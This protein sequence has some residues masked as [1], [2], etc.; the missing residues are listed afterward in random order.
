M[1][2]SQAPHVPPRG[3]VCS[4]NRSLCRRP[5]FDRCSMPVLS[6][7]HGWVTQPAL[8]HGTPLAILPTLLMM[9]RELHMCP[10]GILH[11]S[12]RMLFAPCSPSVVISTGRREPDRKV[13]AVCVDLCSWPL[14]VP[15]RMCVH[16]RDHEQARDG[17]VVLWC[18]AARWR[19][20][21]TGG[22]RGRLHLNQTYKLVGISKRCMR[23]WRI[24]T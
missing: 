20:A 2:A 24:T 22:V 10:S 18:G 23:C 12:L 17:G 8:I 21:R 5:D 14:A 3:I 15:M 11:S 4:H 13:V 19:Q 7:Q 16:E 6:S 1:A 9:P